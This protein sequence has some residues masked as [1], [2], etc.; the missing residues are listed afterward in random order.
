M[1]ESAIIEFLIRHRG[2]LYCDDCLTR[3]LKGY[4]RARVSTATRAFRAATGFYR[5]KE[6]CAGCGGTHDG[7]KAR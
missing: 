2:R 3:E 6:T 4:D 1:L 5:A 7:T